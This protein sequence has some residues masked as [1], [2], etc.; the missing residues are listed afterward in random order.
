MGQHLDPFNSLRGFPDVTL[1]FVL[2]D[3]GIQAGIQGKTPDFVYV[4]GCIPTAIL[5]I[6]FLLLFT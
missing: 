1:T 5:V 3:R 4:S 2:Q 6:D